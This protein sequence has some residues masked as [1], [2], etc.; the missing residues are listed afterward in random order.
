MAIPAPEGTRVRMAIDENYQVNKATGE[1][2]RPGSFTTKDNI[3]SVDNVR[4]D[5]AIKPEFKDNVTHVQEFEIKPGTRVQESKVG[6]QI[7]SD[8]KVYEGGGNQ[9][10]ILSQPNQKQSNVL[11]PIDTP[12]PLK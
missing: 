4:N 11:I 9:V 5:L 6:S 3:D 8:G 2:Q 12:I 10:E 1:V 7:G